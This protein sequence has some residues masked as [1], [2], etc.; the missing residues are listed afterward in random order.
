MTG[1]LKILTYFTVF[2]FYCLFISCDSPKID[3]RFKKENYI[4][5]GK[6]LPYRFFNPAITDTLSNYPLIIFLHGGSGAGTNNI[7]Q[8]SGENWSG[9]HSWMQVEVQ[10][11]NP[12]FILVPQL[13]NFQR[14]NNPLSDSIPPLTQMTL[15]LIDSL[16]E[17]NPIDVNRI[18]LTGQSLGGWGTW[19]LIGKK[20]ELFAAAI[21]VCGGGNSESAVK[22]KDVAIWAFHGA[23]DQQ[24]SV[25]KTREMVNSF[26]KVGAK[27]KYSEYLLAGHSIWDDVYS[28]QDVIEWLFNQRKTIK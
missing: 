12:A 8:I 10:N 11:K 1:A 20:P 15:D 14:W 28:D 13:P 16:I 18:Y 7:N 19:Y 9:S 5:N 23:F 3:P 21:P 4:G 24:I 26:E 2:I 22:A 27:I 6:T 17:S 25:E